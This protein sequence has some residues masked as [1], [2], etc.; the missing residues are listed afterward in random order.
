[1]LESLMNYAL[2]PIETERIM[3]NPHYIMLFSKPQ[4]MIPAFKKIIRV[5]SFINFFSFL[6]YVYYLKVRKNEERK[7]SNF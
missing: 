7:L 5:S 6:M 2:E 4:L 1:M 3:S